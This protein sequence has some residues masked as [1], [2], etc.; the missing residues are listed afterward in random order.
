[1]L[2]NVEGNREYL[3]TPVGSSLTLQDERNGSSWLIT[4]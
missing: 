1:M 3:K 4:S 2:L